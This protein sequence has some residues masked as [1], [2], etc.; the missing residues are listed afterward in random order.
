ML[1]LDAHPDFHTLD[2]SVSGN[3]HGVPLA[4][5]TGLPGFSGYFP[6]LSGP[7]DPSRICMLGIRSVDEAE[8]R[9]LAGAGVTVHGM[10]AIRTQGIAPLLSAFL[11]RVA[12]ENGLLHV[13]L[14]VD[15]LD[16][17]I[18]PAVGTDSAGRH[19]ARR[20]AARHGHT[21]RERPRHQPRPRRIES[22]PS[23]IAAAPPR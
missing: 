21:A 11:A 1:W 19:D 23:T 3:L 14:D 7:I 10:D 12:A 20:G 2:T 17:S 6:E 9:A 13:S 4:Y 8:H 22:R 5:V 16:P 15:F 18:A